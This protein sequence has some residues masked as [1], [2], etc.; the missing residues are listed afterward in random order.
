[1]IIDRL[2]HA[3]QTGLRGGDVA[4]SSDGNF[5]AAVLPSS[6]S[7]DFHRGAAIQVQPRS[8]DSVTT[9]A[10]GTQL[11]LIGWQN[12]RVVYEDGF[13]LYAVAPTGGQPT[14]LT[15]T[16]RQFDMGTPEAGPSRS[17]D[18]T[19]LILRR[20]HLGY[21]ALVDG[22]IRDL[23]AGS[24]SGQD[25]IFWLG[26]HQALAIDGEGIANAVVID[27]SRGTI[28]RSSHIRIGDVRAISGSWV[29][30]LDLSSPLVPTLHLSD[31]D[32][33]RELNLGTPPLSGRV[34]SMGKGAFLL[35]GVDP[36][37][38][39]AVYLA[40]ASAAKG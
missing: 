31:L 10:T 13:I 28:E 17:P 6:G 15:E 33:G 29:A 35:Y 39:G 32:S 26:P 40:R 12:G 4:L 18:G 19:V 36:S 24:L 11:S 16:P 23:P 30:W 38:Q 2:G 7:S 1:M 21:V 27:V 9:V 22:H 14:W 5:I 8:G 37:G 20:G 34:A 3:T 25:G